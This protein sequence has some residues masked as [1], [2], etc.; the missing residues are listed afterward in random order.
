MPL[1][2]IM[3]WLIFMIG[4]PLIS[5]GFRYG[6]KNSLLK[7][8]ALPAFLLVLYYGYVWIN[9]QPLFE[10][11]SIFLFYFIFFPILAFYH[12][13]RNFQTI[14]AID[15]FVLILFLLSFTLLILPE[16]TAMLLV[17]YIFVFL[18]LI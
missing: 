18:Y 1:F 12:H 9:G 4:T 16:Q 5:Q 14:T 17:V 15:F 6:V 11:A 10:G 7:K 13:S 2:F 8:S 3:Y